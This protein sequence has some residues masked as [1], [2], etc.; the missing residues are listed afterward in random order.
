MLQFEVISSANLIGYAQKQSL[1]NFLEKKLNLD[2]DQ[3]LELS[4]ALDHAV[5]GFVNNGGLVVI[6]YQKAKIV[7]ALVLCKTGMKGFWLNSIINYLALDEN[8]DNKAEILEE[9]IIK[10]TFGT[11]DRI[12]ILFDEKHPNFEELKNLKTSEVKDFKYVF[13]NN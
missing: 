4:K 5:G 9:L 3:L 10:S 2:H 7:A 13:I 6:A 11:R 12:A 1:S 8:L